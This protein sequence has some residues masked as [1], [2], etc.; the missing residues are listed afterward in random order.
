MKTFGGLE[1]KRL[2][3]L[4]RG[5]D[6]AVIGFVGDICVD[7]YWLADMKKS[8][9]SRETPHYPLPI[10][11]ERWQLGAGGNV[12]ANLAALK[13]GRILAAGV[14]GDDWRGTL[15]A[16]ELDRL[17]LDKK[18]IIQRQGERTC[19]YCKPL[20]SG[21]SD[22]VYEDPRLDFTAG[23]IDAATEEKLIEYI[24]QIADQADIICV[25]DQFEDGIITPAVRQKLSE[26][27]SK[28]TVVADSRERAALYRG[29]TLKPNETEVMNAAES[30]G[31]AKDEF[32][33]ARLLYENCGCEVLLTLGSRGSACIGGEEWQIASRPVQ[34]PLDICGAGDCF[35][36]AYCA[37]FAAGATGA[38]AAWLAGLASEVV[39]KKIGVTGTADRAQILE[40]YRQACGK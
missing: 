5:I 17:G 15:A 38:E 27:G 35:M 33:A 7:I 23:P 31:G 32:A 37:A 34:P 6:S 29:V 39:I 4:L 14:I 25:S 2:E 28:L 40:R 11:E 26:V 24:G 10:T 9:L 22:V 8:R 18:Y 36:A 13:P 20:R 19:A 12:L 16:G 30:F 1:Q 3:E 21:I